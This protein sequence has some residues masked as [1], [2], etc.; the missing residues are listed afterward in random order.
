[1]V[2]LDIN[3]RDD[4]QLLRDLVIEKWAVMPTGLIYNRKTGKQLSREDV[5]GRYRVALTLD[6]D[7]PTRYYLDELVWLIWGE[8][9]LW[10]DIL[11]HLDGNTYNNNINNME[12]TAKADRESYIGS[13]IDTVAPDA[14]LYHIMV[15]TLGVY[16]SSRETLLRGYKGYWYKGKYYKA[17]KAHDKITLSD[18]KQFVSQNASDS[19]YLLKAKYTN[20]VWQRPIQRDDGI[21][22]RSL[23]ELCEAL[24][25]DTNHAEWFMDSLLTAVEN[26]SMFLDHTWIFLE[27]NKND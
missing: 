26:N 17:V 6:G 3:N 2:K 21:I 15:N 22:Y 27:E 4:Q 12:W 11:T 20:A 24:G 23:V 19:R 18:I 8:L 5:S 16:E 7:K 13:H 9:E 25:V 10:S 14:S 1:M